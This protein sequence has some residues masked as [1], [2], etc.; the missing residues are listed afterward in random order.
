MKFAV[1]GFDPRRVAWCLA[2]FSWALLPGHF[3]SCELSAFASLSGMFVVGATLILSIVEKGGK[4]AIPFIL[5]V[6][7]YVAHMMLG[8]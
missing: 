1:K 6:L 8:H 2:L 3:C 5:A 4:H 7:A